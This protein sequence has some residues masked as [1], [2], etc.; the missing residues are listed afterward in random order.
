MSIQMT[1]RVRELEISVGQMQE[2]L[3]SIYQQINEITNRLEEI[4]P[5][6]TI[7]RQKTKASVR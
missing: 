1:N 2:M 6:V 7:N 3:T 5:T 4:H